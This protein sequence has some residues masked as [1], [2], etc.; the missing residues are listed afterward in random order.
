MPLA[1]SP[2]SPDLR[3]GR[4]L[5]LTIARYLRER[6]ASGPWVEACRGKRASG[7][8][9]ALAAMGLSAVASLPILA[10]HGQ[11]GVLIIG[12][13]HGG[14]AALVRRLPA[15]IEFGALATALLADP[16]AVRQADAVRQ[17]ELWAL[18]GARA[19]SPVFQPI[20]ELATGAIVGYEALTRFHDGTGPAERFAAAR[21]LGLGKVL[22]AAT[23]R[24]ALDEARALPA[25]AWLALNVSA[26]VALSGSR[27]RRLLLGGTRSL[28]LEITEHEPVAQP[29]AIRDAVVRLGDRVRPLRLAVD[30]AGAGF[31]GLRFILDLAP[32]FIKLDQSLIADIEKDPV[33]Q[34]LV[35][36]MQHFADRLGAHLIAEGVET[37]AALSTLSTLGV[38]YGQG[39]LLGRPEPVAAW[40]AGTVPRLAAMPAY[41][42]RPLDA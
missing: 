42:R 6:S 25:D 22:E 10:A 11:V 17:R 28:V 9:G 8:G 31:N 20:V 19:F 39:H 26:D 27:L 35:V 32:D 34:A 24:A 36:G 40:Q 13:R 23:L 2:A 7:Y 12:T 4:L 29:A 21:E 15:L 37:G 16:L 1:V 18:I 5:P 33:K 30:D 14:S 41:D 38:T 3:P